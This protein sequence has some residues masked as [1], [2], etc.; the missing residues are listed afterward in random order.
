L[1]VPEDVSVV[2]LDDHDLAGVLG[3]TTVAQP[4]AEQGK[5]GALTVLE[6]L[7]DGRGVSA[8]SE[9]LPTR[10]VV[11]E[12]TAPPRRR[13]SRANGPGTDDGTRRGPL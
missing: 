3:L 7:V 4:V 1:R 8:R 13:T 9:T 5:R 11:R 10:L 6:P 2:G 12:S